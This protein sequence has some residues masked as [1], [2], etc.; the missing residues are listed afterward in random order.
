MRVP[1]RALALCALLIAPAPAWA[2]KVVAVDDVGNTAPS[3]GAVSGGSDVVTVFSTDF[4]SGMPSQMTAP[5]GSRDVGTMGPGR[6]VVDL[7]EGR[8]FAAGVYLVRLMQRATH[9]T[10]RVAVMR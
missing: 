2:Y 9:R 10:V 3:A 7:A 5:G 6:H 8:A 4:E 1:A